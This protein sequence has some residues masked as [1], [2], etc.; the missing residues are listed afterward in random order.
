M[1]GIGTI[2]AYG[3]SRDVVESKLKAYGYKRLF[4]ILS[5]PTLACISLPL[6]VMLTVGKA[7]KISIYLIYKILYMR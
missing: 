5:G 3:L 7:R 4:F 2:D 6:Y 1:T